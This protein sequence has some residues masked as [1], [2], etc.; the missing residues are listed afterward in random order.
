M[1]YSVRILIKADIKLLCCPETN[2]G[3]D[4]SGGK[5][6]S[7]A[8]NNGDDNSI[9]LTVVARI[10]RKEYVYRSLLYTAIAQYI[11]L[12]SEENVLK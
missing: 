9:L 5:D 1:Y 7:A 8:I 6:G 10:K 2:D 12:F 4:N 3:V 11:I